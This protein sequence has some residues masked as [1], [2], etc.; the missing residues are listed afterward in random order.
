MLWATIAVIALAGVAAG[1]STSPYHHTDIDIPCDTAT[2]VFV[3][4][5]GFRIFHQRTVSGSVDNPLM[6]IGFCYFRSEYALGYGNV[7]PRLASS[8]VAWDSTFCLSEPGHDFYFPRQMNVTGCYRIA[9]RSRYTG[10]RVSLS[11]PD[12]FVGG[13]FKCIVDDRCDTNDDVIAVAPLL[14]DESY[15]TIFKMTD[16]YEFVARVPL[17]YT[18]DLISVYFPREDTS[19]AA[20]IDINESYSA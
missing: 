17:L 1:R 12:T 2:S 19:W 13:L 16:T 18:P 7:R 10:T 11:P 8:A 15:M 4:W 5:T 9:R 20:Y 14:T 6:R 3:P